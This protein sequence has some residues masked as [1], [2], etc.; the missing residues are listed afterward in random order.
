MVA[1]GMGICPLPEFIIEQPD[2]QKRPMVKPAFSRSI[3]FAYIPK[4][5]REYS[6]LSLLDETK[7]SP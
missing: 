4:R 5:E 7:R 2:I 3:K 6:I 1:T